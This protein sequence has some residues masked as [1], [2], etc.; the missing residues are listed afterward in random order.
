MVIVVLLG[1]VVLVLVIGFIVLGLVNWLIDNLLL[2][3]YWLEQWFED[4]CSN[5]KGLECVVVKIDEL[6]GGGGGFL[7]L[8][9]GQL[10]L[11]NLLVGV[12]DF[13]VNV[14]GIVIGIVISVFIFGMLQFV[15]QYIQVEVNMML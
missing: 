5:F 3:E 9:S 2:I 10:I 7:G 4:L 1:L 6:M 8:L 15:D 13:I 12:V 14:I 11:Q